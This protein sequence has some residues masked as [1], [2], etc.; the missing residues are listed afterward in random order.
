MFQDAAALAPLPSGSALRA[1]SPQFNLPPLSADESPVTVTENQAQATSV[2]GRDTRFAER[3]PRVLLIDDDASIGH[4]LAEAFGHAGFII[5]SVAEARRA[6]AAV[7]EGNFDVIL[8]DLGL[9]EIDGLELLRLIKRDTALENVPVIVLTGWPGPDYE[10]RCLDAGAHDFVNKPFDIGVL[11]ARVRSA[12]RLK[13]VH[14]DILLRNLELDA[15]RATAEEN[16]RGKSEFVANMS[17]EIRTPMNGVI[18]M[19]GLV[20]RTDLTA[21]Q[22]EYIETIR[23]SGESLLTIIND[24]LNM[25]K[26][27][28]GKLELENR[29]FNLRDCI[30]AAVDLLAPRAVDK[31]LQLA[32]EIHPSV[33]LAVSGDETRLRQIII[34][35]ISNAVKFTN[36]GD[37]TV[38]ATCDTA[39]GGHSPGHEVEQ[40][41]VAVR[42]T[43][44]GIPADR[45]HKL[46][47]S[48]VQADSSIERKF[49]G[50]GLGLAISKG[51]TELMGG[52]MWAESTPGK[53]STFHCTVPLTVRE[54]SPAV[55]PE[56]ALAGRR[57]LVLHENAAVRGVI[58]RLAQGWGMRTVSAQNPGSV[59]PDERSFDYIIAQATVAAPAHEHRTATA[60]VISLVPFG[61]KSA[62]GADV[63]A[64]PVKA[65]ALR[66]TLLRPAATVSAPAP[67][68]KRSAATRLDAT[69]GTRLPLNILVTDD[70]VINQKVAT[71]LL[72]QLGYAADV[73]GNG[74]E[75][76][77]MSGRRHYD[78]VLMDVQMPAMDGLETT[79]RLRQLEQ[80]NGRRRMAVVAMTANAMAGDR[81]KCLDAGMDDYVAK[82]VRPEA[83]QAMIEKIATERAGA[84]T[85]PPEH[86]ETKTA[87]APTPAAVAVSPPVPEA[88]DEPLVELDRLVEFAGGSLT[89]LVEIT[90]LYLS[91]THEQLDRIATALQDGNAPIVLKFAHSSA[92]ASG[93]CGI[94]AMERLFRDLERI[95]R[96]NRLTDAPPVFDALTRAYQLVKDFLLNSRQNMPLS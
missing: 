85:P 51:L 74:P 28:S 8:L 17:H 11:C 87:E 26:I 33:Q 23:A 66:S 73:A 24:I 41:H 14:D 93:V 45:L 50:T 59:A 38:T 72:Q 15:A 6:L 84:Q 75:A 83:L 32:S 3:P 53:G 4:T 9:P 58:E 43:G 20:L 27:Q 10:T 92:G 71:R 35:L 54:P 40:L 95:A 62:E 13:R 63:L 94:V 80:K 96:D 18:A 67:A 44:I 77:T 1:V 68:P 7:R 56:A 46:F 78:L 79:R 89:S 70:N 88:T 12:V 60:R 36:H 25:A 65:D 64:V 5:D 37:V 30:E 61:T 22:R 55:V 90:D 31:Q 49:G 42:D 86:S 19:T 81:E 69:L 2:S 29:P 34:N 91:Q 16:A 76:L 82:P 48:F 39:A 21:E 52:R 47:Y 57:L